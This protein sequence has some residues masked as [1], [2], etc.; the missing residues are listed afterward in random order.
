MLIRIQAAIEIKSNVYPDPKPWFTGYFGNEY[1]Y[2]RKRKKSTVLRIYFR[3]NP[4]IFAKS[5]ESDLFFI[6]YTD[7]NHF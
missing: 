4:N 3:K 7:A 2:I 1:Q 6:F 5:L